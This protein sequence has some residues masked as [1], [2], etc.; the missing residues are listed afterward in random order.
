M[1]NEYDK[2]IFDFV[3]R[4]LLS[5]SECRHAL[6]TACWNEAG[7]FDLSSCLFVVLKIRPLVETWRF[8]AFGG[9]LALCSYIYRIIG[10][11]C[12]VFFYKCIRIMALL[13]PAGLLHMAMG[14][15]KVLQCTDGVP[16]FQT[17]WRIYGSFVVTFMFSVSWGSNLSSWELLAWLVETYM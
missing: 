7:L 5:F 4:N 13:L 8:A 1:Q 17:F 16:E 12:G 11:R 14:T 6:C 10:C 9:N 15:A 3:M 2:I